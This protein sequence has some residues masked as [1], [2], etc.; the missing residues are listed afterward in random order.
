MDRSFLCFY[1]LL[2]AVFIVCFLVM[3]RANLYAQFLLPRNAIPIDAPMMVIETDTVKIIFRK[4]MEVKARRIAAMIHY[5]R[6]HRTKSMDEQKMGAIP[7]ILRS[8]TNQSNGFVTLGAFRSEFFTTS[9]QEPQRLTGSTPWIDMLAI[10]EYRHVQQFYSA[11]V[12]WTRIIAI[13]SGELGWGSSLALSTP[14]W[15]LEGDAVVYETALT[16]SGRGRLPTFTADFRSVYKAGVRYSYDKAWLGTFRDRRTD[17]YTMGYMINMHGREEYGSSF[18]MDVFQKSTA[19]RYPIKNMSST[20][21][22]KTGFSTGD[23]YT[24]SLNKYEKQWQ[25]RWDSIS[26]SPSHELTALPGR[27]VTE[28]RFPHVEE[29]GSIIALKSGYQHLPQIVRMDSTG[30]ER[31]LTG[32]GI[33]SQPYLAVNGEWAT[34]TEQRNNARWAS[35][36]FELVSLFNLKTGEKQLLGQRKNWLSPSP[37]KSGQRIAIVEVHSN[38]LE[39]LIIINNEGE[40]VRNLVNNQEHLAFPKWDV[41]EASVLIVMS[42]NGM[43]SLVQINYKTKERT[44]LL[45]PINHAIGIPFPAKDHVFFSATLDGNDD[46]FAV[47]KS[48]KKLFKVLKSD[49]AAY[50]AHV[51]GDSLLFANYAFR[52]LSIH[53]APLNFE[54]VKNQTPLSQIRDEWKDLVEFEGGA[55]ADSLPEIKAPSKPYARVKNLFNLHSTLWFL[56]PPTYSVSKVSTDVLG[57]LE[58]QGGLLYNTDEESIAGFGNI[59]YNAFYVVPHVGITFTFNRSRSVFSLAETEFGTAL[60]QRSSQWNERD[61]GLGLRV[62]L[63]WIFGNQVFSVNADATY[64]FRT[65]DLSGDQV[66]RPIPGEISPSQSLDDGRVSFYQGQI[67]ISNLRRMTTQQVLPVWG[68]RTIFNWRRSVAERKAQQLFFRFD[69]FLPGLHNTHSLVLNYSIQ[70]QDFLDTYRFTNQLFFSRG[71]PSFD[72]DTAYRFGFTYAFPLFYPHHNWKGITYTNRI[73]GAL[74]YDYGRLTSVSIP[75]FGRTARSYG[76]DINTNVTWFRILPTVLNFRFAQR[77]DPIGS[78]NDGFTFEFRVGI[79]F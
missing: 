50:Q 44:T 64:H 11:K 56:V 28:Y 15:F 22:R 76:L 40:F 27:T 3:G 33:S 46:I 77:L 8:E 67:I 79:S 32:V 65:F 62:P 29:S 71:Y 69:Q 51:H 52:G 53:S 4:K 61:I 48:D 42:Q 2:R 10:H 14:N 1:P 66:L 70:Q 16:H 9:P 39:S 13:L 19:W 24:I 45:G 75:I 47:R 36:D 20:L 43:S 49:I 7:I 68:Q 72:W 5:M 58:I 73:W 60:A 34:W 25:A 54:E 23:F 21:K 41:D 6:R 63:E 17:F 30:R 12:G 78:I 18:W 26:I 59:A 31:N 35:T 37:T 38:G 55:I 74:F 57:D